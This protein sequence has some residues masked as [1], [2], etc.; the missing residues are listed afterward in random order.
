MKS[1]AIT[2]SA[3][4]RIIFPL[5]LLAAGSYQTLF[6]TRTASAAQQAVTVVSAATFASDAT[7]A[8]DS[9]AAAFGAFVTQNGQ[10]FSASTIPLPTM[11]GGVSVTVNG[12]PA[13]LF[14]VSTTQINLLIPSGT[15]DG[16]AT[17]VVTSSDGSNKSGTFTVVR[18]QPGIFTA[19]SNLIVP[20]AQTT[21]D[22]LTY[23][24]TANPDGTA[25]NINAGTAE[26]PNF[27]V[28]YATGLRNTPA[29][30]PSDENGVAEALTVTFLGIP[31]LVTY[32]GPSGFEGLDQVNVRIPWELAGLS[33]IAVRILVNGTLVQSN[34][35]TIRFGGDIPPT[36]ANPINANQVVTGALTY[37]DQ[38]QVFG[39]QVFFFDAYAF[40]STGNVSVS[41]DLRATD[42]SDLDPYIILYRVVNN[43][44]EPVAADDQ[45]GGIGVPLLESANNQCIL[46]YTENNNALLVTF[47]RDPGLYVIYATSS[48]FQPLGIGGY[49]IELKADVTENITYGQTINGSLTASDLRTSAGAVIDVYAFN[50]GAGDRIQATLS[51]TAFNGFILLQ[52][53]TGDPAL[54]F[55]E[56]NC[57]LPGQTAVL[58]RQ[59]TDA[60]DYLLIVYS[61]TLGATGN[62]SL[63]LNRV[64]QA[65]VAAQGAQYE[66]QRSSRISDRRDPNAV[67]RPYIRV[68]S[69]ERAARRRTLK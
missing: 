23:E 69:F 40:E 25:R 53:N 57:M 46:T 44:L 24:F 19:N 47:L 60:G 54:D 52:E 32:A 64:T 37:E 49:T 38:V 22:G 43:S 17:I 48:D 4:G 7:V 50:A 56:Q 18:S 45:S 8:P 5:L 51:S 2:K 10:S 58:T 65:T 42:G 20:A 61:S 67:G 9:I 36:R 66:A 30:N 68:S 21:F 39:D 14:F 62:Y 55:S 28:L 41:I 6:M 1:P 59:L 34:T 29:A 15:A 63:T 12:A 13:G 35:V 33:N 27:L 11:L 16:E 26:M 3:L 31:G